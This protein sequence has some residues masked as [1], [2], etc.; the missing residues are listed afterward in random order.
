MMVMTGPIAI[1][2]VLI[3]AVPVCADVTLKWPRATLT[4]ADDATAASLIERASGR[5]CVR[6]DDATLSDVRVG[7]ETHRAS[8]VRRTADGLAIE[9]AG[10]D[11]VLHY[12]VEPADDWLVLRLERVEGT[13][14]QRVTLLRLPVAVNERVG[15]LLNIGWD[16][17]TAVC[18]M[19]GNLQTWC[20]A[21]GKD[22]A[23][24]QAATQDHPGPSLEGAAV[25]VIACPTDQ[26]RTIARDASNALG[27][28][29]NQDASG[30]PVKDTDLVRGSYWFLGVHPDSVDR[31][32]EYC[33]RAGIRQ[34]MMNSGS[35]CETVGH[36]TFRDAYPNGKEDLKAVVDRFHAAG[37]LVGMHCFVS[38]VSKTDAYVTPV[39]DRRFWVDMEDELA[40]DISADATEITVTGDLR[41]WAGSPVT[42]REYW[43]GGVHKHQECII[44]DEII[45]Y[46]A[47]GPEGVWNS[48]LGCERGAWG[49]T[50]AGHEAGDRV[51]HYGVDGCINGYIIDQETDLMDEVA[52]RIS[53]IFNYCGFDMVYFDGGE[54]VDRRRFSYYSTNFQHQAMR[55]FTKRPI[56]HMGTVLTHRLWHSFARSGTVDTYL[57]TLHGAIAAG[58]EIED[59]PTVREHI[60]R[61]V[62]RVL[63]LRDDMMPAELGW[64]GIWPATGR[65][66]GLQLDEME[67]L[68]CKSLAL[69]APVSLQTGFTHMDRHPL[70]PEILAIFRRY[71]SLRMERA[72]PEEVTAPLAEMGRDFAM[73]QEA[74]GPRFVEVQPVE[75]VG[76]G[77]EVRAL[78]GAD[79]DG[80]AATLWHCKGRPGWLRV[81]L[82]PDALTLTDFAGEPREIT[83]MGGAA[84]MPFGAFR[85]TLLAEGVTPDRLREALAE[86]QVTV[87]MPE[88]IVVRAEGAR[89]LEG[90]MALGSEVGVEEPGAFGDVLVCTD[91]PSRETPQQWYAQYTVDIPHEGSW[92]LWARVRY[93]R[94]VDDSFALVRP[95][96]EVTLQ[97]EQVLGNCGAAGDRW[98]WTGRGFGTAC[99]PPGQPITMRLEEGPFTFRVYAREGGGLETNPRLDLLCLADD[100]FHVPDDSD[101]RRALEGR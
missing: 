38:K 21:K 13:R 30:T 17:E 55:R 58:R 26:F 84:V 37:I 81:D 56:I 61:S 45:R 4:V 46:E 66:D 44:G 48:F 72:L 65:Y 47:I 32:I 57:N 51:R 78:V 16:D 10:T 23:L 91:R 19:A 76:G 90:E 22:H 6:E 69:D 53:D 101:A 35:W 80:S 41:E 89:R 67:Y 43:E 54:D 8:A 100:P 9:Y 95:G 59:W 34:V 39:P 18:L 70:T 86:A 94:G 7:E 11:T 27:L 1:G 49:T 83:T 98:H 52:D 68:M 15:R 3:L 93:P 28:P 20:G 99:E 71:E 24:L 36:Y 5:E 29:T 60:D 40:E 63:S 96:E 62:R 31:V 73:L 97:G 82:D 33:H 87:R 79:G 12:A 77:S 25:A 2:L 92:T 50:A 42:S 75:S 85:G 64:F 88:L 74:G 14:P